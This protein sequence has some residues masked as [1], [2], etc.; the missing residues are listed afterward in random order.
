[1]VDFSKKGI[2][3]RKLS[4]AF[5]AVAIILFGICCFSIGASY[6]ILSHPQLVNSAPVY[7][8]FFKTIPYSIGIAVCLIIAR[9]LYKKSVK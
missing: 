4:Y 8:A 2:Y 1:M 3:M 9:I 7:T 6:A 5:I